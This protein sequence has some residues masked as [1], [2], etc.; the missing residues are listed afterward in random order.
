[1]LNFPTFVP[2]RATAVLCGAIAAGAAHAET[3]VVTDSAHPVNLPV[4]ASVRLIQLDEQLRLEEQISRSLPADPELA[5]A[6]ARGILNGPDGVRLQQDL[7][8][9][10]QG[11]TDAWSV[12]VAKLPA[13][14][15][16]RQYVVYGQPDVASALRAIEHARG[17][18]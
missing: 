1:M 4:G 2:W 9:A 7:A 17:T 12:G 14:V 10:Q 5:A 18:P 16:D 11:A 6:A 13:V 3:W 8:K 15:V